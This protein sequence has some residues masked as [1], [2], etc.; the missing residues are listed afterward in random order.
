VKRLA[1]S[2]AALYALILLVAAWD[3]PFVWLMH[4]RPLERILARLG[5]EW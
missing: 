2:A 4:S 5:V 1:L 3:V